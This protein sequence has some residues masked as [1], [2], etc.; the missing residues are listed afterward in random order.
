MKKTYLLTITVLFLLY[1]Y[2]GGCS[3][4]QDT[5]SGEPE[6]ELPDE[7]IAIT[8][9]WARPGRVNGVTAV[10]LNAAN[11]S[12]VDDTLVTLSSPQAGLVELHETFEREEGMM[13]MREVKEA[14]FPG[15]Q[16]V[17]MKPGGLHIM[18]MQLQEELN[19]GDSVELTLQFAR[20]GEETITVPVRSPD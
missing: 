9:A 19:E 17:S 1:L 7:G 8:D 12:A 16:V 15:S 5:A 18:L 14:I 2:M 13:G 10:Y 6:V 4:Q 20:H 3:G 11:G